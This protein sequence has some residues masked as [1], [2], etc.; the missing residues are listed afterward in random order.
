MENLRPET[1]ALLERMERCSLLPYRWNE[2]EIIKN[3]KEIYRLVDIPFSKIT[4]CEDI[5]DEKYIVSASARARAR[6]RARARASASARVSAIARA[7]VSARVSASVSARVSASDYDFDWFLGEVELGQESN[8]KYI[9]IM[10]HLLKAK[11][12]GL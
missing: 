6:V 2:K 7:R 1:I 10:E 9:E 5:F 3:L 12:A 8:P 11:E 4:F